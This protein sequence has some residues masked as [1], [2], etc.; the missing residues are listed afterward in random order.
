MKKFFSPL[1][2]LMAMTFAFTACEGDDLVFPDV[3]VALP[4]VNEDGAV[5]G[6][7]ED[8]LT[9]QASVN[10]AENCI[11]SWSVDG[12]EVFEGPVFKFVPAEARQYVIGLK[13][14]NEY[15][16]YT[17]NEFTV[18]VT[19]K[20][21]NGTFV[22][23]EGNFSTD[24][25]KLV[26][27]SDK[28]QVTDSAYF[29]ANGSHLGHSSQDLFIADGKIYIISQDNNLSGDGVLVVADAATLKK[30]AAYTQELAELSN[31]THIVVKG[32]EAYIRDGRGVNLFNLDTKEVKLISGTETAGSYSNKN[33]MALVDGKVYVMA[34]DH[35]LVLEDGAIVKSISMDGKISGV[36]AGKGDIVWVSLDKQP[37][38]IVKIDGK[39]GHVIA[40]NEL[41]NVGL[42]AGWGATPA[43]SAKG[44]SIYFSNNTTTIYRHIFGQNVTEKMTDVQSHIADAA[45]VY[46]NLAVHPETGD[47]YFTSI[48]GYGLNYLINDISVYNFDKG[49]A[50]IADYKN[51][52]AFPAGVFFTANY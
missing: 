46:N 19:G 17:T 43:I 7:Q 16:V 40:T 1:L 36:V 23:N 9:F 31:P 29:K 14:T 33:R 10:N 41:E 12:D 27:I 34:D 21:L 20:F 3:H 5:V 30:E 26:F 45:M 51:F 8:T 38:A 22:L 13:T 50:P 11:Y 47:V 39:D 32:N 28:G 24:N 49:E 18:S 44:D 4:G 25:G 48:K 6:V 37:A 42:S 35:L 15:G 52:T 2:L